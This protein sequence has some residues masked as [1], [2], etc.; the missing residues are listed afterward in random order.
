MV[1]VRHP[2]A[3]PDSTATGDTPRE[4]PAHVVTATLAL[5]GMTCASCA[6]R[7]ERSLSKVPGVA[8]AAVNLAT[9][10]ASVAYAAGSASVADLV[11]AVENAGYGAAEIA[12]TPIRDVTSKPDVASP[13]ADATRR[14]QDVRRRRD[15]LL[16]GVALSAPV[17]VLSMFFMDRFP[18]ENLL[19][20]ALTTPVWA[21]VGWDFHRAALRM[22]RHRSANMD[23]LVSLGSTAAFLM[24]VV[25][26]FLPTVVGSVTFYDTT[27]L[28][29]T[30]IY[31]GKYLE[32][33]A[34]GQTGEAIRRLAGLRASTAH[35]IRD[36]RELDV[37]VDAVVAGDVLVVRPG[38][39]VPTDGEVLG[40]ASAVDESML[41]G[42]SLPVEK[43]TGDAVVGATINQ[44]GVL[45]I[46]ATRVGGD[47]LLASI[48]RLVEQA[49]GS[50]API[51]RLADTVAGVFVPVVLIIALLTFVGWTAAGVVLGATLAA[52]P[53]GAAATSPW[54][55]ALVAAIA[56]LVVACPCALGLATPTAIMVGTGQGAELGILIK[57]GASLERIQAVTA[58]VLDKTGTLTRGKPALTDVVVAPGAPLDAHALLRLAADAESVSEHPLAHAIVAGARAGG[59]EAVEPPASFEAVPG[60]GVAARIGPSEVVLGTRTLL[61][62]RGVAPATIEPLEEQLDA[63]ERAGKTAMLLARDGA[64]LGILAVADTLKVGS[65]EAVARL[66]GQGIQVWMMSGDNRRTA[67]SVAAQTGIPADQVLAEVLP[68]DKASE[69]A[70]L[71]AAGEVVA[72][73][74]DGINDAPALAQADV[75]IAMGSGTD[76]ALEAADIALV[77]GNLRSLV[78]ALDLS[79]ATMRKIRQNLFWAFAYNTVLIPLA[80]ASPALPLLRESAPIFAAAAMALSSVTVVSN[81]LALRR[82]GRRSR[83]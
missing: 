20:L 82:F 50:K 6:R 49:Q 24:S 21:Y 61:R 13:D 43:Q 26:T 83:A 9:E 69:V 35:V 46:R 23:V 16:L 55:A 17:L 39:K 71:Q 44:T 65:R 77:K 66:H 4:R 68:G 60:G 72:F 80:I 2:A 38:E 28:I 15:T 41:T 29:V 79:R 56:V 27:A 74:G 51:Q 37:P 63:L 8:E 57:G 14:Q 31:L 53:M 47:T 42:E 48:I 3:A 78:T 10:R 5:E 12:P 19:L 45:R 81:S 25:A 58:V 36:G 30:L 70:R 22:L 67:Q 59:I 7:I 64:A 54:I 1:E 75:G 11:A 62:A 34:K 32:A 73:A 33:R 52:A 18:G 40:G 76:I